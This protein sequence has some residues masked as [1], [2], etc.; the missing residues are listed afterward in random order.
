M[1]QEELQQNQTAGNVTIVPTT[2]PT[3]STAPPTSSI[4]DGYSLD[5]F[6]PLLVNLRTP[7]QFLTTIPTFTPQTFADS[8]QFYNDGTDDWLYFYTNAAWHSVL[9]DGV[10]RLIAGSGIALSPTNGRGSVTVS[11]SGFDFGDGSDGAVNLNGSNTYPFA[12][13][14]GSAYTL[15]RD[16]FATT[17]T[18]PLGSTLH[19]NGFRVFG[20]VSIANAGMVERDGNNGNSG[21]AGGNAVGVASVGTKGLK[22]TGATALSSGT[23]FGSV[24]GA[25]G[26]DGNTNG[27]ASH[28][29]SDGVPAPYSSLPSNGIAGG[30][31]APGWGGNNQSA[32]G[33]AGTTTQ[34]TELRQSLIAILQ[35]IGGQLLQ[36]SASGGGGGGGGS[37]THASSNM[38]TAGGGGGGGSGTPGGKML[39]AAPVIVNTGT[40]SAKG[41]NG[42]GGGAGG[43]ASGSAQGNEGGGGGGGAAP[44]NGG[45]IVFIYRDTFTNSGTIDVSAGTPGTG[46]VHGNGSAGVSGGGLG[47]DGADASAGASGLAIQLHV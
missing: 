44:G 18:V 36:G 41:G 3:T 35:S 12:T 26:S 10:Q 28:V 46:G 22:G 32:G 19:A 5:E 7:R 40:C 29:A 4:A 38:A 33:L 14:S 11:A 47:N 1:T 23:L 20:T 13:K 27:D 6:V 9:L 2:E 17:F 15:T 16:V 21:T 43:S 24:A 31:G 8:I 39:F 25:D 37:G 45:E 34:I 42:G 30:N